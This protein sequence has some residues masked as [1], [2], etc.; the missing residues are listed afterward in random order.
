M[1]SKTRFFGQM[2]PKYVN[3]YRNVRHVKHGR[4]CVMPWPCIATNGMG[5]LGLIYDNCL[6]NSGTEQFL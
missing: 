4:D 3:L 2:M 6:K 5:S 1:R